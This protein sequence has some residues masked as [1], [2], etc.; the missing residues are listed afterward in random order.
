MKVLFLHGWQSIPGDV[1]PMYL[2]DHGHEIIIPVRK[3]E[4]P[5]ARRLDRCRPA[6]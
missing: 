6:R 4:V 2:K 1:K 5:A 3:Y